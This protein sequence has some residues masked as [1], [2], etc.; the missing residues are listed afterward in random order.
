MLEVH[1]VGW[2]TRAFCWLQS[3]VQNEQ[4]VPNLGLVRPQS[5]EVLPTSVD[6]EIGCGVA[7]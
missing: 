2:A 5:S 4:P 6:G 3:T 1:Q 7:E